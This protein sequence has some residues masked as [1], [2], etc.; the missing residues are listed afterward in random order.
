MKNRSNEIRS[1]EIRIRQELPVLEKTFGI[2]SWKEGAFQMWLLWNN[3]ALQQLLKRHQ[4]MKGKNLSNVTYVMPD[5]HHLV[6]RRIKYVLSMMG[7]SLLSATFV[8]LMIYPLDR[9]NTK[10]LKNQKLKCWVFTN[11][12]LI[13]VKLFKKKPKY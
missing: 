10:K 4:F 5:S 1:N 9:R 3:F 13:L 12:S 6:G 7:K 11:N 2:S 8:K